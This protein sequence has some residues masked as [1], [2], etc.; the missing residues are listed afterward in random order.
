[1]ASKSWS[2]TG[3]PCSSSSYDERH[4]DQETTSDYSSIGCMTYVVLVLHRYH[5]HHHSTQSC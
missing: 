1:M 5:H 2:E 4:T 3:N